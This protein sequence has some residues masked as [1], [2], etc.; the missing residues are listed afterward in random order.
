MGP[1]FGEDAHVH[2]ILLYNDILTTSHFL[3]IK[4]RVVAQFLASNPLIDER[5]LNQ[6]WKLNPR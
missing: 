6:N 1:L 5:D 4:E 2:H 3:V